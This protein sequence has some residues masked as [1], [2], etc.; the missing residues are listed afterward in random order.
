M[1]IPS[2][3]RAPGPADG[4]ARGFSFFWPLIP[5]EHWD[6]NL[7]WR[8]NAPRRTTFATAM[9]V[10]ASLFL[11]NSGRISLLPWPVE[12]FKGGENDLSGFFGKLKL[13]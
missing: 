12:E 9:C 5:S 10:T 11:K 2:V 13:R 6:Y 7:L 1:P 4:A 8:R 3:S